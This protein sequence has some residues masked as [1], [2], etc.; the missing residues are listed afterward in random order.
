MPQRPP[1]PPPPAAASGSEDQVVPSTSPEEP[2]QPTSNAPGPMRVEHRAREERR[3]RDRTTPPPIPS[4]PPAVRHGPRPHDVIV[5][6]WAMVANDIWFA[7]PMFTETTV[8]SAVVCG[9][10]GVRPA[11]CRCMVLMERERH[12]EGRCP[13]CRYEGPQ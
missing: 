13:Y 12:S 2:A 10:C 7:C 9:Q 1:P 8:H 11:C 6:A 3:A 5:P 4:Q